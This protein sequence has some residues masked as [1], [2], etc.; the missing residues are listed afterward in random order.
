MQKLMSIFESKMTPIA[1]KLDQNRYLSAIKNAFMAAMPLLIVGSFFLLFAY[2]PIDAYSNFMT[3]TF[4]KTWQNLFLAPNDV[5]MNMMS[6]YVIIGIANELAKSYKIDRISS[7]FS[8]L[9]AFFVVTPL[10]KFVDTDLGTGIPLTNVGASG[11]FVGMISS[12]LAVEI[13]RYTVKKGWKIT[14]PD[15]VPL[16]VSKS[17]SSLIPIAII[18]IVFNFVRIVFAS[19]S[20]GSVQ[21]FI[22]NNLQTPLTSLGST[23]PATILVILVE[24]LLW[25]FGIHGANIV[26]SIMQPIWLSLTAQNASAVSAGHRIPNIVDY[27]FYSNFV[28]VGG[29]GATFGLVLLL[30]FF[31]KSKQ[32]KAIGKLAII[33]EI[34][35]INEPIIFGLPIVLNPMLVLPFI[36]T[37]IIMAIITY[38]SMKL[39]IVPY[40]NGINIPW[41]TPPII[42]GFLV[43]GWRGALLNVFQ[44]F[45]SGIIYFPF[46]KMADNL[47]LKSEIEKEEK[48]TA[49]KSE[50]DSVD[51]STTDI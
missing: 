40:T 20:F 37:P 22:F 6:I 35:T 51:L 31:A 3:H 19:T 38:Y 43:S 47:A 7:I 1:V 32:F 33:P 17:F 12:I 8:A 28:K 50:I 23:L 11:L 26:G 16:N 10:S 41:T 25:S 39:G 5:T 14:M 13:L 18:I 46:F 2:M 15:S 45:L 48:L 44:I 4:G 27:Q 49:K 30:F 36:L 24:G 42:A 21:T 34:F 29:S 9:A